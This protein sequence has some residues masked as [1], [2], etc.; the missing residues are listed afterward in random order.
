VYLA[1]AEMAA[2]VSILGKLPSVDEYMQYAAKLDTMA[3]Q[4]YRY[5]NFDQL[6]SFTEKAN[7]ALLPILQ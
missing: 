1:S 6:P 2:I 4:L 3:P 5:L 7:K